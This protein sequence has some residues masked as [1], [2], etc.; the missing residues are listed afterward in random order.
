MQPIASDKDE[1]GL[2]V[3]SAERAPAGDTLCSQNGN[4][5]KKCTV[6]R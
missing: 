3:Q 1:I 4:E 2:D 5:H 6:I